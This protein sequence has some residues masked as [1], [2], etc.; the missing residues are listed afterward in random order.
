M[1]FTILIVDDEEHAR[2]HIGSFLTS[3]GY[4]V[5]GVST[6][7]EAREQIDRGNC[8]IIL[9]DV[10]LPDGYGPSLIDETACLINR[11]PI[12]VITAY[13]DIEMAVNAMK[14]GAHDFLQK[15]I[16][17]LQLEKSIQRVGDIVS[18]RRELEHLRQAQF[19]DFDFI[20]GRSPAM[21]KLYH[22]AQRAAN[23]SIPVLITG[24]TG[25]GKEIMAQA[26]A[27]MGPRKDKAFFPVNC[28]AIQPTMIESEL[29]GH[30]AGAFTSADKRKIGLLE[31][32]NNG[33]LFLDEISS[34]PLDVQAKLLRAIE[35]FTFSRVGGTNIL[36]VDVQIIAASNRDLPAM[37]EEGTFRSDLFW[38]LKVVDLHL[39]PLCDRKEDIPDLVGHFMRKF[40]QDKGFNITDITPRAME[41]LI[42]HN[43][44][45]NIRELKH[46]V[47]KAMLFCD[48]PV[49]DLPHLPL[50]L[51][52][53]W[54]SRMQ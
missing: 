32:T 10:R 27:R 18:L 6:L 24:P 48:D 47:E 43:W 20:L 26:I 25:S 19:K 28:A 15:P 39:P 13:G 5:V 8:D 51:T 12:I 37:V 54:N 31:V 50:E 22:H 30:E 52:S 3:R 16:D 46:T 34:M 21:K 41:V 49:L 11:P 9:L 42:Y 36:K 29:F 7:G 38:R 23:A 4:E 33:I 53:K 2:V 35:Y 17:L 40:N 45:G 44:P 1:S 14:S